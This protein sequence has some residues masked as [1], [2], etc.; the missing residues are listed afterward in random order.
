V[1]RKEMKRGGSIGRARRRED[2]KRGDEGRGREKEGPSN[3][4]QWFNYGIVMAI[5]VLDFNNLYRYPLP[6]PSLHP[7]LSLPSFSPLLPLS[8][9]V[10]SFSPP[11]LPT[12][13]TLSAP[14]SSPSLSLP[15]YHS[16]QLSYKP[17]DYGQYTDPDTKRI[18]TVTN[19]TV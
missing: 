2:W 5:M 18:Y 6:P 16:S 9:Y 15:S 8:P 19:V 4:F 13:L 3:S 7:Y 11:L 1:G 17:W 14:S 10:S 12:H